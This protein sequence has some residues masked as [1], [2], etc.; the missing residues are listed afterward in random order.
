MGHSASDVNPSSRIWVYQPL[1]A[2]E[3]LNQSQTE[4]A[5]RRSEPE[6]SGLILQAAAA[7]RAAANEALAQRNAQPARA[8]IQPEDIQIH[9]GRIEVIA[10]PPPAARP[11]A[12]QV[13]RGQSLD[14]YLNGSSHN[15]SSGRSR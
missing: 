1:I 15:S 4:Q 8:V 13:R 7:R 9:I 3:S 6:Q 5:Q 14:E 2:A 10:M 11:A 12:A